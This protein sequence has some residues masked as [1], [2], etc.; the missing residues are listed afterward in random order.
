MCWLTTADVDGDSLTVTAASAGH[1]TVVIN[2]N[3]TL[4]YTPA[5]NYN[6]SDT[7]S[8]TVSDG[9]YPRRHITP[10]NDGHGGA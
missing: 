2:A 9:R 6:G 3:G 5:A 1:G 10:V 8:Y 4:T 7:I